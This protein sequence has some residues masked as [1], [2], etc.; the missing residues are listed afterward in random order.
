MKK[1]IEQGITIFDLR[2]LE[3]EEYRT[4]INDF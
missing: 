3:E 1:N 2:R 4:R